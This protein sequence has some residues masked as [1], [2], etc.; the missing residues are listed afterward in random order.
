M[1]S[2]AVSMAERAQKTAPGTALS[3]EQNPSDKGSAG[4]MR[5]GSP[6]V[7]MF[8]KAGEAHACQSSRKQRAM[9]FTHKK[10]L[11][12]RIEQSSSQRPGCGEQCSSHRRDIGVAYDMCSTSSTQHSLSII[13]SRNKPQPHRL[14]TRHA[15]S[16]IGLSQQAC[17]APKLR[18][19]S[20]DNSSASKR[21]P[22]TAS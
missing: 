6:L 19:N 2:G 3:R 11:F 15:P 5:I 18:C 4:R 21:H 10:P 16:T 9:L 17:T 22:A 20:S 7:K 8:S 1:W 13:C 12:I 14:R